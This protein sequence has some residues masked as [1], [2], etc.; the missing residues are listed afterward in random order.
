MPIK[1]GSP[2]YPFRNWFRP[3]EVPDAFAQPVVRI[4]EGPLV[5]PED[6][7]GVLHELNDRQFSAVREVL[8][9]AKFKA[10]AQ[11]RDEKVISD[12]GKL[13]YYNGWVAYADFVLASLEELRTRAKESGY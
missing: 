5:E 12:Y 4:L 1:A 11:V 13:A 3:V 10:A 6:I 9:E 2:V 8:I 7:P